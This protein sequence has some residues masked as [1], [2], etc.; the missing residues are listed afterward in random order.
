MTRKTGCYW[1]AAVLLF[2][3]SVGQ[4]KDRI[5]ELQAQLSENANQMAALEAQLNLAQSNYQKAVQEYEQARTNSQTKKTAFEKARESYDRGSK[6]V[7]LLS[8]DV[9]VQLLNEYKA[10]D[11]A[12]R[13]AQDREK[14]AQINLNEQ[15]RQVAALK[16]SRSEKATRALEIKAEL[17]D[18]EISTPVWAEGCGESLM[19]EDKTMKE[20]QTLALEAAKRDALEKGGK[21]ILEAVTQVDNFQLTSDQ[22]KSHGSVRILDQDITGDFGQSKRIIQNEQIKYVARV[23]L[24]MQSVDT[25]NPYREQLKGPRTESA[26]YGGSIGPVITTNEEGTPIS[27]YAPSSGSP[28]VQIR[29]PETEQKMPFGGIEKRQES[30]DFNQRIQLFNAKIKSAGKEKGWGAAF[31][32]VG[33]ILLPAGAAALANAAENERAGLGNPSTQT[34]TI[35][36]VSGAACLAVGIP[37]LID[38]HARKKKAQLQLN[39]IFR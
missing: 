20:C 11:Q 36:T 16:K 18:L 22:I 35:I 13:Q 19:D 12:Y 6:N 1:A 14:Q 7:D 38:A 30:E 28:T 8:Q 23:R 3:L 4:G 34:G 32:F 29:Q 25:Y 37:L 17:F 15:E 39:S 24:K 33:C 31:V 27:P 9:L 2:S 10:A 26:P 5:S 21:M